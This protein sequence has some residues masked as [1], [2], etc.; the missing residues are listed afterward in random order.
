MKQR[1]RQ[2]EGPIDPQTDFLLL[3]PQSLRATA[4]QLAQS[5][6][7]LAAAVAPVTGLAP[8]APDATVLAAVDDVLRSLPLDAPHA[9]AVT[10]DPDSSTGNRD[11]DRAF[12]IVRVDGDRPRI[13]VHSGLQGYRILLAEGMRQ[14]TTVG[15]AEWQQLR[16]AFRE[17]LHLYLDRSRPQPPDRTP[18]PAGTSETGDALRRWTCGH[19][20]FMVLVQALIVAVD[21]F[22]VHAT[23]GEIGDAQRT[24][25]AATSLMW[26][27]RA[28]LLFTGDFPYSEYEKRVR[29]TLLP[30]IA[31]PDMSGLR[32]RDHEFLVGR[33]AA[34]RAVFRDLDDRLE[35]HR[36][37]FL[38]ALTQTYE[39]HRHVCDRFVG[40]EQPSVLMAPRSHKPAV[41]MLADFQASRTALV[42]PGKD[43]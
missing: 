41:A 42:K 31:P 37:G 6:A 36:E 35:P 38:D 14:G 17:L 27:S 18:A 12:G 39:S 40:P 7:A 15:P 33:L 2:G 20:I 28:A 21:R 23:R 24:L 5:H 32:W 26:G 9:A 8:A 4:E 22:A 19:H 10:D 34:C 13:L 25:D 16:A 3:R 29:P 1:T 11:N 43:S 30:P